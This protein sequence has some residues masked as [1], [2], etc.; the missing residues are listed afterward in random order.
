MRFSLNWLREFVDIPLS[1]KVL[2]DK[3]TMAGLEVESVHNP[4]A[5]ISGVYV[6]EVVTVAKHPNADRLSLCDVKTNDKVYSIV[7]GA[8]NMLPGDKV[9]LAL[10]GARLPKDIVIKQ[11]KIRGVES[12]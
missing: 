11:S 3:L 5:E 2:A 4:G 8:K 7:C 12:Q 1:P 10:D 6:A 9:A